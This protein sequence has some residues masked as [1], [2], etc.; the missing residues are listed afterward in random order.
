ML[1]KPGELTSLDK[2]S[3]PT[4]KNMLDK[5]FKDA[6]GF[7]YT[8]V[9]PTAKTVHEGEIV[10]YDNGLGVKAIY[11]ITAQGNLGYVNLT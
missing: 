3:L 8:N 10:V 6:G 1:D 11:V 2:T 4:M 5:I 7:R 9:E